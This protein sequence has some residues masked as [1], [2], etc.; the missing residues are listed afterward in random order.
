[1]DTTGQKFTNK[2]DHCPARACRNTRGK[3]AT[4]CDCHPGKQVDMSPTGWLKDLS[5]GKIAMLKTIRAHWAANP[6]LTGVKTMTFKLENRKNG[7]QSNK[8]T[9]KPGS[10]L[11]APIITGSDLCGEHIKDYAEFA[12]WAKSMG[13][14]FSTLLPLGLDL[15]DATGDASPEFTIQAVESLPSTP[16]GMPSQSAQ[17]QAELDATAELRSQLQALQQALNATGRIGSSQH[18]PCE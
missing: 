2:C 15:P 11:M 13:D 9:G 1:M 6:T 12:E 10:G 14:E 3:P 8:T 5:A 16:S 4:E 18:T 17:P 7:S